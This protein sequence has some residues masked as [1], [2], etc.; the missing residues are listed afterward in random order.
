MFGK[1]SLSAIPFHVPIIMGSVSVVLLGAALVLALITYYG[2]WRY[3]WQEW[4][5][6]V[7]H[8]K[9]G[10]MYIILA[11]IMPDAS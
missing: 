10:V 2:K 5:T 9:I 6:S 3:L 7:D 1:L 8:K 4:L 11:L